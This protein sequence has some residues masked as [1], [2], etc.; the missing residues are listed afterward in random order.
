[1]SEMPSW[2]SR[3]ETWTDLVDLENSRDYQKVR[4]LI[5]SE[6]EHNFGLKIK[7]YPH[8]IEVKADFDE[9]MLVTNR[10]MDTILEKQDKIKQW[11]DDQNI[12]CIAFDTDAIGKYRELVKFVLFRTE[13]DAILFKL[14]WI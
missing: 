7:D 4:H 5:I 9:N 6:A 8:H 2:W 3:P 12:D 11:C 14:T 10:M 13:S 1:M